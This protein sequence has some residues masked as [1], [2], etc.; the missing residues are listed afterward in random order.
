M[1]GLYQIMYY[2]L[3][4]II[5]VLTSPFFITLFLIIILQYYQ[6]N[7]AIHRLSRK[8]NYI[9]LEALNSSFFGI[10]GGFI[11]TL[12]FIYLEVQ[13]VPKEYIYILI[14]AI[15]LS[16]INP[17][18]MCFAYSGSLLS[19]LSTII[20]KGI[21][22]RQEIMIVVGT[23]HLV[24][25]ILIF[26][27][28]GSGRNSVYLKHKDDYVGGYNFHR[29]WP[30]PFIVFI[31]DGLIRPVP[32]M[33][34]LNYSDYTYSYPRKK[35][36]QTSLWML[37]YSSIL[38]FF[39]KY[40][41]NQYLVPLYAIFGHEL[42]IRLN[43]FLEE[44]NEPLFINPNKGLR[45]V[46]VSLNSIARDIGIKPGDIVLRINSFEIEN[47]RDIRD[48]NILK[49]N[50]LSIDYFSLKKGIINREYKGKRKTLGLVTVPREY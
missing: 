43:I 7:K 33:A 16:L 26:I 29:F 19:L 39:S 35:I 4:D 45:V 47:D 1:N 30:V 50:R 15:I 34:I 31:W 6:K 5:N 13:I 41:F 37:L 18:F 12:A 44:K 9:F 3:I 20:D 22:D 32:F 38:L 10:I 49:N 2:T 27:N 17:R 21:I 8:N 24:E 36:I 14:V 48:I 46:E 11:T 28:G 23:L 42:I 25:S 40:R